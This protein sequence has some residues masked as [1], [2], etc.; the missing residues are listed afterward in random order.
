[1]IKKQRC[2]WC[3]GNTLYENYHD[4]EW[5][6][7]L[8]DDQKLFEFIILETFQAGMSWITILKKH[9]NFR[10][11]FDDFD[12]KKVAIYNETKF[13]ELV[14]NKGIVRNKLKI[15]AAI[16]NAQAFFKNPRRI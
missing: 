3:E 11:A 10:S 4:K 15:K 12:Y 13:Q 16:S 2:G 8:F 7:P 6:V 1:M 9:E 14:Q 5:G